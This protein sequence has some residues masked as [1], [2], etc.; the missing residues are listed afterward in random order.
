MADEDIYELH[1]C[2]RGRWSCVERFRSH[3]REE[4]LAEANR[5]FASSSVEAVRVIREAYDQ[6]EQVFKQRTIF[7]NAKPKADIPQF[8]AKA[9]AAGRPPPPPPPARSRADAAPPKPAVRDVPSAARLGS[10]KRGQ[11][12]ALEA[13][14]A[15]VR[16]LLIAALVGAILSGIAFAVLSFTSLGDRM[17]QVV[18]EQVI[19]GGIVALFVISF[20]LSLYSFNRTKA[21][22]RPVRSMRPASQGASPAAAPTNFADREIPIGP[23]TAAAEK[24]P[25]AAPDPQALTDLQA[26]EKAAAEKAA[27]EKAASDKAAKEKAAKEQAAKEMAEAEKKKAEVPAGAAETEALLKFFRDGMMHP[28]TQPFLQDGKMAPHNRFGCH[29]FLLGAGKICLM[30]HGGDPAAL[31]PML[32]SALEMLGTDAARARSFISKEDEYAKDP[33]YKG[34][35]QV[36]SKAMERYLTGGAASAAG[37]LG[38]ALKAWNTGDAGAAE[39]QGDNIAIMFTD[40]VS[41][42]ETTQALGD[43]GMMKLVQTHNLIIGAVLKT[44]RGHQ[45]K[46][47]GD[48]IMA[49]FPKVADGV[50]AACEIQRQIAD[51]N[52]NTASNLLKVRMGLAVGQ[53][54]RDQDDYFGTVVQLAARLCSCAGEAQIC[55]ASAIADQVAA[56]RRFQFSSER[57][58]QLK[59]FAEAQK[60]RML[61]WEQARA[62]QPAA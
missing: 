34:M 58:V 37:A 62:T 13:T 17:V 51:H 30:A 27:A 59:G 48:G 57:E 36:G 47:T 9:N 19:Y 3:E 4:A 44:H 20:F 45:V 14:Y 40:M 28:N 50:A 43:Q 52:R 5:Q 33:K 42:V 41:S 55:V 10:I 61:L 54:I 12:A 2:E 21:D 35:I 31:S 16:R 22:P 25:E 23:P 1:V 38:Q 32:T 24:P 8:S 15:I 6:N 39:A 11:P 18:R 29:L 49:V 53:P 56:S 26:A 46:H 60:M 7:R